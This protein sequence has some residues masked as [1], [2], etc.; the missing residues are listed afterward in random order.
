MKRYPSIG[1]GID[2]KCAIELLEEKYRVISVNRNAG[3]Y[4]VFRE[5]GKVKIEEV[6][7]T[8]DF[9]PVEELYKR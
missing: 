7:K 6:E 8:E 9:M 3:A 1:I 4:R 5:S 2:E